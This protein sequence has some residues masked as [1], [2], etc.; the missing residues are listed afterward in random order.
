MWW[1]LILWKSLKCMI[2]AWEV[3]SLAM[4]TVANDIIILNST[5][6]EKINSVKIP[7]FFCY[8]KGLNTIRC[9]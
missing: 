7:K 8:G 4:A 9:L 5:K 2:P 1:Q 6:Y 3:T